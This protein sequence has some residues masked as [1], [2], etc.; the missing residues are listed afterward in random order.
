MV[1][2]LC[3]SGKRYTPYRFRTAFRDPCSFGDCHLRRGKFHS[4]GTDA[5]RTIFKELATEVARMLD[6]NL[7]VKFQRH[8]RVHNGRSAS[9]YT[10]TS[11][12]PCSLLLQDYLRLCVLLST[13]LSRRDDSLQQVSTP[14]RHDT[15]L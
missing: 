9:T 13:L 1:G 10:A 11:V 14:V 6:Q 15:P 3:T 8:V 12:Y 4:L 5:R 2:H 7:L